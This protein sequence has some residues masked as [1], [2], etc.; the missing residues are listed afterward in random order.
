MSIKK[1]IGKLHLWLGFTS[2]LVVFILGIT[3]AIYAFEEQ[4]RP[5]V[6]KN[7]H[8][9]KPESS[10]VLPL[11]ELKERAQKALAG[12][13]ACTINRLYIPTN[14]DEAYAFGAY[15]ADLNELTYF[16]QIIC[17]YNV[18]INPYSGKIVYVENTKFEF[19]TMVEFL[20]YNLF[21]GKIGEQITGW[22]TLI[23]IILLFSGLVLWFPKNK[24]A[25]R[26]RFS[27]QWR[28]ST[29]WKRKNYDLHNIPGFYILPFALI[30]AITG[31]IWVFDWA[32]KSMRFVV[33][34][35]QEQVMPQPVFS[36]TTSANGTISLDAIYES[37]SQL[38]PKK[39]IYFIDIPLKKNGVYYVSVTDNG[40]RRSYKRSYMLFDQYTGALL[41]KVNAV[42]MNNGDRMYAMNFDIHTG[43]ILELPGIILAFIGSLVA[44][45]L[46]VTGFY[47][48]WGRRKK[49]IAQKKPSKVA[50]K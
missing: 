19:F 21:L 30:M 13:S 28:K 24:A 6:Y 12:T 44:A 25:A 26:Q 48:W 49:K 33:N 3:G 14:P 37:A 31:L 18:M 38:V 40:S 17:R 8:H 45:S 10:S 22:A 2:G 47:I 20:H 43:R 16:G 32:N 27:F 35:G 1:L 11:S 36:D 42:D 46:P 9:I 50:L 41:R 39:D 15:A 23:F 4:L 5:V 7:R 34:G 29:G